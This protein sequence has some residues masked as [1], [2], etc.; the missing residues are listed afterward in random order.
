[1]PNPRRARW[2]A[3]KVMEIVFT[4]KRPKLDGPPGLK[5]CPGRNDP[6]YGAWMLEHLCAGIA[7]P[8]VA[9]TMCGWCD[10]GPAGVPRVCP[11]CHAEDLARK[12]ERTIEQQEG[13]E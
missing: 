5:N 12:H 9:D 2:C 6:R 10:D 8:V 13:S 1:M 7:S 3:V 11:P 4:T